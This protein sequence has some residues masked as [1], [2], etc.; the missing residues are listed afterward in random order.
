VGG[1][2]RFFRGRKT[3]LDGPWLAW[4]SRLWLL[5]AIDSDS[6]RE[7]APEL[8]LT[9]IHFAAPG[10]NGRNALVTDLFPETRISLTGPEEYRSWEV[11]RAVCALED[12]RV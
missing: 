9:Q 8:T 2:C 1:F 5:M 4:G 11:A 6:T 10:C 7:I 3:G 12:N